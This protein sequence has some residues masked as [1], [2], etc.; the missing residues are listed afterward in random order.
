M[1]ISATQ[2]VDWADTRE[3]QGLLPQ[4]IRK[5]VSRAE[6]IRSLIIPS[7]DSVG[8]PGWDG[9]SDVEQGNAWVPGGLARWE[10]GCNQNPGTKAKS[11]F[12]ARENEPDKSDKTF[13]FITPRRWRGK[14]DWASEKEVNSDWKSVKAYDADDLEAWL[15]AEPSVAL[16]LAEKLGI[17]GSGTVSISRYWDEWRQQSSIPLTHEAINLDQESANAELDEKLKKPE[18][19]ISIAADSREQAVAFA[20]SHLIQ[21]GWENMSVCVTSPEGWRFV[22][23]NPDVTVGVATTP[24]IAA[25]RSPRN[26][27][28][29]IVPLSF[30]DR[31]ATLFG[32]VSNV[33][34]SAININRPDSG[35]FEEALIA[36]GE[37]RTDAERIARTTGRSWSVYRRIRAAN[38]AIT[39]PPWLEQAGLDSLITLC[40]VGCWDSRCEGD[41]RC[42]EL[43]AGKSYAA[44]E[45]DLAEIANIDDSPILKIGEIWK[46]KAPIDLLHAV[47]PNI[48]SSQ[49]KRFFELLQSVFAKPDP[50]LELEPDQR[51][52]ANIYGK[53]REETGL[54][55]DSLID[56]LPKL[57]FYAETFNPPNEVTILAGV[58]GTV[59]H[60]LDAADAERWLSLKGVLREIAEATPDLFL[61][62]IENSLGQN[63]Q[64]VSALIRD[65]GHAGHWGG[66][67]HAN[68]L[69]GLEVIA[70][71]PRYLSRVVCI[72]AKLSEI[73]IE[74]N[75]SNS[76][77]NTLEALFVGW[78]PQTTA[79]AARRL[80]VLDLLIQG[81]PAQAWSLMQNL[82]P[83]GHGG[84]M[85]A[86]AKPRWREDNAGAPAPGYSSETI[87]YLLSISDR[88]LALAEGNAERI[89]QLLNVAY[90]LDDQRR[91]KIAELVESAVEFSD[92]D[93]ENVR[94][95]L[96]KHLSR[97]NSFNKDGSKESRF[98]ADRLRPVFDTLAPASL[99]MQNAWIFESG[100]VE[101]PDGKEDD[102][103]ARQ[104]LHEKLRQEALGEVFSIDGWAGINRMAELVPDT[105]LLGWQIGADLHTDDGFENW[106]LDRWSAS[107]KLVNDRLVGSVLNGIPAEERQ[108]V[109]DQI[110]AA[111]AGVI[112]TDEEVAQ[113]LCNA[114]FLTETWRRIENLSENIQQLYWEM[115]PAHHAHDDNLEYVVKHLLAVDRHRSA[116]KI[117]QFET[118]SFD[119]KQLLE[120]LTGIREGKEP[121]GSLPDGWRISEAINAIGKSGEFP[122]REVAML[123]FTY[124]SALNYSEKPGTYLT[125]ELLND[126]ALFVECLTL[127]YKEKNGEPKELSEAEQSAAETAGSV[128]QFGRGVPGKEKDGVINQDKLDSWVTETLRLAKEVDRFEIAESTTGSWLSVC[129]Q[130]DDGTWPCLPVRNLL[131]A[132][133]ET[134]RS[135]FQTG[136]Y[137]NRGMTSRACG[138]GGGQ[139]RRLV[140]KYEKYAELIEDTHPIVSGMLRSIAKDY[141]RQAKREDNRARLVKEQW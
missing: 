11:D 12:S 23:A 129:P 83:K 127:A 113:F 67:S 31:G 44:L 103:D 54:I 72:L 128:L 94:S 7:G 16:W 87:S 90:S 134:L 25:L 2:L 63:D 46:V 79:N 50:A 107:G 111:R 9:Q 130:D 28:S 27:F 118:K 75:W 125:A 49:L 40:L 56:A 76:P 8:R 41:R 43:I 112:D 10:M 29:M 91:N 60:L 26:G 32:S 73:P 109:Y 133:S 71:N 116:F 4:V 136:H 57:A 137:N 58:E 117:V 114:P 123:E 84:I 62:A 68:L 101:L 98:L 48:S 88:L 14:D 132:A 1:H 81:F 69:W 22:N 39:S 65:T 19:L 45:A 21:S 70:W 92:A 139:E 80:K 86:N 140:E 55:L 59:R 89:G 99:P 53:S 33:A 95:N 52:M 34:D 110:I 120:M 51:W 20:C 13:V 5:L 131:E 24:E 66:C 141:D 38:P 18:G 124:Y 17:F 42:V 105:W 36:L 74:G 119:P 78:W 15:E 100:W 96:R 85:S 106:M 126:P 64:P 102:Y 77:K 121:D 61:S 115:V 97:H 30:G 108:A 135:G 47:A 37:E 93:R 104:A 6:N 138:E 3:A 35:S 82:M 122:Q